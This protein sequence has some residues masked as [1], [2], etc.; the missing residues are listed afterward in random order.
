[1]CMYQLDYDEGYDLVMASSPAQALKHARRNVRHVTPLEDDTLDYEAEETR[2]YQQ[3]CRL[4][5]E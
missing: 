3:A 2:H 4:V 5:R 1:M